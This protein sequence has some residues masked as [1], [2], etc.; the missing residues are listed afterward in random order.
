MTVF[1]MFKKLSTWNRDKENI[2]KDI[3]RTTADENYNVWE[4]WM[5]FTAD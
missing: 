2:K 1:H 3:N 5:E 4:Y